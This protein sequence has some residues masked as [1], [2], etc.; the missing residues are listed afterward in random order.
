MISS[1]CASATLFL[2]IH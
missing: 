1:S 2:A